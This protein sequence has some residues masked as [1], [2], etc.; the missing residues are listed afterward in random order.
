VV[1][2][3]PYISSCGSLEIMKGAADAKTVSYK[4]VA[5]KNPEYSEWGLEEEFTV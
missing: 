3:V 5:V 1:V 2:V 4:R